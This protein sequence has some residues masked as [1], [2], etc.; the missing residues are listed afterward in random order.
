MVSTLFACTVG[1]EDAFYFAKRTQKLV[2]KSLLNL[3]YCVEYLWNSYASPFLCSCISFVNDLASILLFKR[4]L[5]FWD[6]G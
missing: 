5:S 6:A 3:V 1:L 4:F 2:P